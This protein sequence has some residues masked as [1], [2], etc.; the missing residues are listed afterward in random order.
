MSQPAIILDRSF[1]RIF[2]DM[3]LRAFGKGTAKRAAPWADVS[4]HAVE[5]WMRCRRE[6]GMWALLKMIRHPN[7]RAELRA[8]LDL[9]ENQEAAI[10]IELERVSAERLRAV[11]YVPSPHGKP[12]RATALRRESA[13]PS[14]QNL[15]VTK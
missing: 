10:A 5:G 6:P 4:H 2:R 11:A 1:D 15:A 3:M 13:G 8:Y 14:V 7:F 12:L 9:I